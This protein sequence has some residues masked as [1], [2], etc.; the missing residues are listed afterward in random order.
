MDKVYILILSEEVGPVDS[1]TYW[2]SDR[3]LGCYSS[4]KAAEMAGE[5]LGDTYWRIEERP[6]ID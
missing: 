2:F 5:R 6:V 3:I 4:H 1:A